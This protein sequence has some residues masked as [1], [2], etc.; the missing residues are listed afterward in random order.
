MRLLFA[1]VL[2]ALLAAFPGPVA[3]APIS[4]TN[5]R[6]W[7]IANGHFYTQATLRADVGFAVTNND[8]LPFWNTYRQLG[9]PASLGYPISRRF[10]FAGVIMQVFERG[11][12]Q[13]PQGGGPVEVTNVMDLFSQLG[14]DEWLFTT[15]AI[16]RPLP[17]EFDGGRSWEQ[18]VSIRQELLER[19]EPIKNKY[20]SVPSPVQLWGVPTSN[21]DDFSTH[22][23]VRLQRGVLQQW[24]TD[25]PWAKAGEVTNATIGVVFKNSGLV[26]PTE[27]WQPE[28]APPAV[29][30]APEASGPPDI[31]TLPTGRRWIDVNVSTQRATAMV[32]D[33]P[34]FVALVTTGKPGY[35]TP[36]GT[37]RINSRVFNETMDSTSLGVPRNSSEGYLL[38]NV[39]FTQYFL[40]GGYAIHSNYWQPREVFGNRPTSHGCVGLLYDDA[41]FFWE[42]ASY[43]TEITIHR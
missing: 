10:E 28:A 31:A 41:K 19:S 12:L 25:V 36:L 37:F 14:R 2:C 32:D 17:P 40:A 35:E 13:G 21:V 42:F 11:L 43:G 6:D 3:G 18:I 29:A 5:A 27:Q 26:R 16:P 7:P 1:V 38:R 23:T 33:T 15:Y 22:V 30:P 4:Q 9:G 20:F 34:V 39:Y 24:K 8:N